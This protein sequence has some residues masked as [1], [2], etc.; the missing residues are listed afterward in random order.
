VPGVLKN[1]IDAVSRPVRREC[2]DRQAGGESAPQVECL[3]ARAHPISPAPELNFL[4]MHPVSG[5]EEMIAKAHEKFD[6][7][8]NLTDETAKKLI[9][10]RR[11]NP[12]DWTRRLA[13]IRHRRIQ[14][15][16]QNKKWPAPIRLAIDA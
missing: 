8:G 7:S 10:Q 11:Q 1:A 15:C 12:V 13:K 2:V 14:D 4:D 5:P 16:F 9:A 6:A 3:A